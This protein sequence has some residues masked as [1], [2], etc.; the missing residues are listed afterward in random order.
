MSDL[1]QIVDGR[2]EVILSPRFVFITLSKICLQYLTTFFALLS[3]LWGL[4]REQLLKPN[5]VRF[6]KVECNTRS[7][8]L[9]VNVQTR[10]IYSG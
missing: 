7:L 3:A 1:L 2:L 8:L 6:P 9:V 5:I 10:L 4:M